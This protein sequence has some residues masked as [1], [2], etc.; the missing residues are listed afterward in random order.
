MRPFNRRHDLPLTI[1]L[2]GICL[3]LIRVSA[4][5]ASPEAVLRNYP[6]AANM[7]GYVLNSELNMNQ[8]YSR[9]LNQRLLPDSDQWHRTPVII[10]ETPK[11]QSPEQE[12]FLLNTPRHWPAFEDK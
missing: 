1:I 2:A 4:F 11:P 7:A 3:L 5:A 6:Q 8:T 12:R 9:K 10:L